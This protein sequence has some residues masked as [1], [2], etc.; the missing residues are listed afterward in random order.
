MDIN[1]D[2]INETLNPTDEDFIA[3]T[4][5]ANLA[6]GA[7]IATGGGYGIYKTAEIGKRGIARA[8]DTY[9]FG[10]NVQ[11]SYQGSSKIAQYTNN[12]L[13]AGGTRRKMPLEML[14]TLTKSGNPAEINALKQSLF[15]LEDY[16]SMLKSQGHKIPKKVSQYYQNLLSMAPERRMAQAILQ[17][18]FNQDIGF[19]YS[20]KF[21]ERAFPQSD[22]DISKALSNKGFNIKKPVTVFDVSDDKFMIKKLRMASTND[23]RIQLISK[24]LKENKVKEAKRVAKKGLIKY[25]GKLVKTGRKINLVKTSNGY[26]VKF[27]PSYTKGGGKLSSVKEY[28]IGGHTQKLHFKKYPG[29]VGFYKSHSNVFDITSYASA[30]EKSKNIITKARILAAGEGGRKLG[31]HQPIVTQATYNYRTPGAGRK[32]GSVSKAYKSR[33]YVESGVRTYTKLPKKI[34][35]IP[36]KKLLKFAITKGRAF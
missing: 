2:R 23:P 34:K 11:G 17:K 26:M 31:I 19:K 13:T 9:G 18:S 8:I 3:N 21:I 15:A 12:L 20:G 27:V 22:K 35:G 33:K 32:P 29:R 10:A 24:L 36:W 14:K 6:K 30:G 7:A 25:K 4:E 28:V 5:M 16:M 1:L